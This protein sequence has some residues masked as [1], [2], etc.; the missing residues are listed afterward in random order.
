MNSITSGTFVAI[1][2]FHSYSFPVDKIKDYYLNEYDCVY[3]LGD[4]TDRGPTGQGAGGIEVLEQIKSL[5]EQFPDRVFY[6]PGNHDKFFY[7]ACLGNAQSKEMLFRA[8]GLDTYAELQTKKKTDFIS[9]DDLLIWLG[10]LPLQRKHIFNGKVYCLAHAFFNQKL[11]D[12]DDNFCLVDL[13]D[14]QLSTS[15]YNMGMNT[16]Q[17]RKYRDK[18]D[19]SSLPSSENIMVV[20]H[21]PVHLRENQDLD[22]QNENGEIV[23][24][25]C[26]DG[27]ISYGG[28]LLEYNGSGEPYPAYDGQHQ[29][30]VL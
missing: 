26:V 1:S 25:K 20:G 19:N 7:E 6:I 10:E 16:L 4:A 5:C 18:Y 11:Y 29:H 14:D 17:F 21:T 13:F 9:L 15:L 24:V 22:L 12:Y 27:G 8:G 30:R 3:I 2:D 23:E 28:E